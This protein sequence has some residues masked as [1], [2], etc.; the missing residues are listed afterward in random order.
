MWGHW[1]GIFPWQGLRLLR[2]RP[3]QHD[4]DVLQTKDQ[5]RNWV[6]DQGSNMRWGSWIRCPFWNSEIL[7]KFWWL[8]LLSEQATG[9][10]GAIA[11][12]IY[13]RLFKWLIVKCNN[14]LID[15]VSVRQLEDSHLW[16]K[17]SPDTDKGQLLRCSRHRRLRNLWIQRLWANLDQFCQREA[18]AVLQPPH[19]GFIL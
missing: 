2:H 16:S 3:I 14:T 4:Q 8:I 12:A 13:D 17:I 7:C 18:S 19:V 11:R 6:G 5:G 1:P 15:H 10:V 9:A